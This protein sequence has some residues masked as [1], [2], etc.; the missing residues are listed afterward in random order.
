MIK[1]GFG[2]IEFK[3]AKSCFFFLQSH[4]SLLFKYVLLPRALELNTFQLFSHQSLVM[5]VVPPS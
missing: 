3:A 1:H 2:T 4:T 5:Q